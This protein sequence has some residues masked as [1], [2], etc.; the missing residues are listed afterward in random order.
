MGKFLT[1]R[2]LS[3]TG[4]VIVAIVLAIGFSVGVLLKV[5]VPTDFVTLAST[6]VGGLLGFVYHTAPTTNTTDTSESSTP[7]SNKVLGS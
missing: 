7:T 2:A 1:K 4:L 3:E 6:V 5:S